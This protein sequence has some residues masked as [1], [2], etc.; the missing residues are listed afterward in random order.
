[1]LEDVLGI[2]HG[3]DAIELVHLLDRILT[4]YSTERKK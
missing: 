4:E 3:A 2:H 1:M